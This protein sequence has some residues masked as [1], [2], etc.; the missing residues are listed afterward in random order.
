M[1]DARVADGLEHL[2]VPLADLAPDP[3]NPKA[4]PLESVR[5]LQ[6]SLA[7]HGQDQPIVAR[8]ATGTIVKGN[9]RYYAMLEMGWTHAAVLFVND[10]ELQAI[11]RGLS[12]HGSERL[13]SER[14]DAL[15]EALRE[16]GHE[17]DPVAGFGDVDLGGLL[18][19][20]GDE[21]SG[22]REPAPAEDP[23]HVVLYAMA[24]EVDD[25]RRRLVA[26]GGDESDGSPED[27]LLRVARAWAAERDEE[28]AD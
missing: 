17:S 20:G 8:R 6:Q 16:V 27:G 3:D 10:D 25:L 15:A 24:D 4:H 19:G 11:R 22:G 7:E 9:G 23:P 5:A 18:S 12:D 26:A 28:G 14:G 13:G 2:L 1:S 21:S